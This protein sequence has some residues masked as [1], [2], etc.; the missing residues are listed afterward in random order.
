[1]LREAVEKLAVLGE[2]PLQGGKATPSPTLN[3][4]CGEVCFKNFQ[5]NFFMKQINGI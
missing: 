2:G 5:V 1:M 4:Q 3:K